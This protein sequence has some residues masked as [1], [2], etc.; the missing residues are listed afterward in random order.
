LKDEKSRDIAKF[1]LNRTPFISVMSRGYQVQDE[2]LVTGLYL[3]QRRRKNS[4]DGKDAEKV[5]AATEVA[6]AIA[7]YSGGGTS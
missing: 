6:T 7:D 3:E 4:Q 5:K 1:E 2:I